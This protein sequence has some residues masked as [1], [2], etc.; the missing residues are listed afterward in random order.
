MDQFNE[1]SECKNINVMTLAEYS[2]AANPIQIYIKNKDRSFRQAFCMTRRELLTYIRS[3]YITFTNV[4]MCIYTDTGD[5]QGY[6]AKPTKQFILKLPFGNTYITIASAAR[7]I[8][9]YSTKRWYS[10]PLNAGKPVPVGNVK[11]KFG[12][13]MLHGQKP[14]EIVYKLFTKDELLNGEN[15]VSNNNVADYILPRY[16]GAMP[17]TEYTAPYALKSLIQ[18]PDYIH[19]VDLEEVLEEVRNG[20]LNAISE[21]PWSRENEGHSIVDFVR[22]LGDSDADFVLDLMILLNDIFAPFTEIHLENTTLEK[23]I[24]KDPGINEDVRRQLLKWID[25]S[26][27][28]PSP[29]NIQ[30]AI[31]RAQFRDYSMFSSIDWKKTHLLEPF[32]KLSYTDTHIVPHLLDAYT[33]QGITPRSSVN[34]DGEISTKFQQTL[35]QYIKE[36]PVDSEKIQELLVNWTKSYF[37]IPPEMSLTPPRINGQMRRRT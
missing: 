4:L 21:L 23:V 2:K 37:L 10:L 14:G 34:S 29:E 30:E 11:G 6:G 28:E 26:R 13:S 35:S 24:R 18:D 19:M 22:M 32:M 1:E 5:E 33:K 25:S 36:N 27:I 15:D 7:L 31:L 9:E 16:L 3:D 12:V 17:G 8:E 20:D